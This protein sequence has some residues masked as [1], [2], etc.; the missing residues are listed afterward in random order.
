[1]NFLEKA[2]QIISPKIALSRSIARQKT[3][4]INS[5][6]SSGYGNHGASTKKKSLAGWLASGGSAI[7]DIEHNIPALRKRS[8]DLFMG[9]PI[10]T[11][12]LKSTVTNVV[13][14]GL[15]LNAQIDYEYL[16]MTPEEADAWE[17]NTEREFEFWA[18]SKDCDV[19]RMNNFY[20]LQQL[21]FLSE[22]QSGD[23]FALLPLVKRVTTPYELTVQLVEADRVCNS[24]INAMSL[25]NKIVNG[26]EIDSKGE[27]IAYHIANYHPDSAMA[28]HNKWQ[29][30]EKFGVKTGRLNVLHL[31]EMERPEQ[32]RGVPVLASVFEPLKQL[33]RYSEAE[34][35]A[36]VISGMFTVF[37][38]T[39]APQG[40]DF[41][42]ISAGDEID[43]DDD[44]T[45]ELGNGLVNYLNEGEKVETTNPGR[46]NT[47][48]DGFVT[49]IC[50]QIGVALEVPYE[51]LMK[52]FTSSYSASRGALLEAWK[53]Y[54][55]RRDWLA[56]DFC[57]PI[58]EEFLAEA[59]AKGR[60]HAPGFFDDPI[61]RKAYVKAEWNGPTQ[62]QLDPKKEV[63]AAEL[64]VQGGFST[65]TKETI[66]LT[67][68]DFFGNH[69]LRVIEEKL[70]RE[71]GLNVTNQSSQQNNK[72][73][74]E[75][76]A[77][78]E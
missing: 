77:D 65:R 13:G 36:S 4:L 10:A 61:I 75:D 44:T 57:Q 72:S 31:M 69:N 52:H 29:R 6:G 30:V 15:K 39:E 62:G 50:R 33:N 68:G 9:A 37:V 59:I 27:V 3:D 19:T 73:D 60:I 2:I 35:M 63:E 64:R 23:V 58:Y 49:S 40:G 43:P 25:D 78:D 74:K 17:T 7:E 20:E 46:P 5:M 47:A 18:S 45:V 71:A 56:N 24:S 22:L 21:A 53:M 54:K 16:G 12:A 1:M 51:V 34:L 26:V 76:D 38:T 28:V 11:G 70:R 32:R 14:S 41:G 67:G 66:E 8:R 48:F 42:G 55:R